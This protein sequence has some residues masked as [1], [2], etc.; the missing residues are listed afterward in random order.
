MKKELLGNKVFHMAASQFDRTADY[1]DLDSSVRERCKWPKR[2]I[3]LTV[4]I[5]RD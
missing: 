1:L 2:L 4:P 5:Q 3:T